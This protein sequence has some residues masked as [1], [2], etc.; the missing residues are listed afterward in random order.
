[1]RDRMR[2]RPFRDTAA[3]KWSNRKTL[4]YALFAVRLRL[5]RIEADV[6]AQ[7]PRQGVAPDIGHLGLPWTVG[8]DTMF[9]RRQIADQPLH[10][11]LGQAKEATTDR[12]QAA[13]GSRH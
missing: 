6:P 8:I 1:E 12:M 7:I 13:R 10:G 11:D 4:T 2:G 5:N 3:K 9:V